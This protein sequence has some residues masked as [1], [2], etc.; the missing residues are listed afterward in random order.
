MRRPPQ[1]STP[2]PPPGARGGD[3]PPKGRAL[4][5]LPTRTFG[6]PPGP[7]P[8]I[9]RP[10]PHVG[11]MRGMSEPPD[12]RRRNGAVRAAPGAADVANGIRLALGKAQE[13]LLGSQRKLRASVVALRAALASRR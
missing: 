1:R 8:G 2:A 13:K 7:P 5:A 9:G 10:A 3:T 11:G 6:A 12:V 4:A